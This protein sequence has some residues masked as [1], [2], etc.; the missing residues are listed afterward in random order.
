MRNQLLASEIWSQEK[1]CWQSGA[2]AACFGDLD[3]QWNPTT[4]NNPTR[5]RKMLYRPYV[6]ERPSPV[7]TE[8][9]K[10][11]RSEFEISSL[12]S[13]CS[14]AD[15]YII[16]RDPLP[17]CGEPCLRIEPWEDGTWK[18]CKACKAEVM[19]LME[20]KDKL[21]DVLCCISKCILSFCCEFMLLQDF[22]VP[23]NTIIY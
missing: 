2:T 8:E 9:R 22:I 1:Q 12:S 10:T 13:S 6:P 5:F 18:P 19:K 16:E 17:E 11:N 4:Q 21:E 20:E 7:C 14:S 23:F 3:Q 15:T